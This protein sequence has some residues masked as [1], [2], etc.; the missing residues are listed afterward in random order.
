MNSFS[1]PQ[2]PRVF[3]ATKEEVLHVWNSPILSR[4]GIHCLLRTDTVVPSRGH[5][6]PLLMPVLLSPF[7]LLWKLPASNLQGFRCPRGAHLAGTGWS[8]IGSCSSACHLTVLFF[9]TQGATDDAVGICQRGAEH[10]LTEKS[11]LKCNIFYVP[12]IV[13]KIAEGT[14]LEL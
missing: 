10:L 12:N 8:H 11:I 3:S 13:V 1:A 7:Y 5:V 4:Y 2:R 9:R 14:S 6:K